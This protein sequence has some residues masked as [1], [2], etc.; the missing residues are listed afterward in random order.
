M[1][2]TNSVKYN[3]VYSML[4]DVPRFDRLNISDEVASTLREMIFDGRLKAGER[5]NEISLSEKLGISRTPLREALRG[6][7]AEGA[8]INIPRRGFFVCEMTSE[9]VLS[10]YPIRAYLDPEA[11]RLSGIPSADR[12]KKL[13]AINEKLK[14]A[15]SV[16]RAIHWDD[17][18]HYELWAKCPN[19][20]LIDLI[21]QF[22]RRTRRYEY[23]SMRESRNV[24]R[25]I[26]KKAKIIATLRRGDLSLACTKLRQNLMDGAKPVL[27]WLAKKQTK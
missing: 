21:E 19:L 25:S 27:A 23:A 20:I 10:I 11:L 1:I 6:L 5:I 14:H 15:D 3:T 16:K 9:E 26:E 13:E 8:F 24:R 22:M 4:R 2:L 12:F 7:V 17:I 18:W